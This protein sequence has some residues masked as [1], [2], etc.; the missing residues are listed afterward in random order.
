M[1]LAVDLGSSTPQYE[2]IRAQVAALILAGGLHDGKK[3]PTVR[4]LAADLGI[5]PGTVARAYRELEAAQLVVSRRRIGTV[6]TAPRRTQGRTYALAQQLA[7]TAHEEGLSTGQLLD[8]VLSATVAA[9]TATQV[10][11]PVTRRVTLAAP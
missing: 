2:Q 9:A 8:L 5:A 1:K 10:Q 6:V 3:L 4:A 11:T 7:R